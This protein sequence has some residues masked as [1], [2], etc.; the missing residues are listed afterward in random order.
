MH[1][2]GITCVFVLGVC[3]LFY[4]VPCSHME[5]AQLHAEKARRFYFSARLGS[6]RYDGVSCPSSSGSGRLP[7]QGSMVTATPM[8][9]RPTGMSVMRVHSFLSG[10]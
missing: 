6:W 7:G 5:K 2:F 9:L 1:F 4:G 3:S 10:Q 8:P